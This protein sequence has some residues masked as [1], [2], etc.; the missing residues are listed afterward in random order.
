MKMVVRKG[1]VHGR[2]QVLH[3]KEIEYILAAKMRCKVLYIGITNP[4]HAYTRET[5]NDIERSKKINN[6]M[7]YLERYEMIESALTQFGVPRDE[8]KIIPF[9]IN[10]PDILLGYSPEDARYFM[11]IHDS[12][13]EE[14]CEILRDLGLDVEVLWRRP[15]SEK[16]ITGAEVRR[17][18]GFYKQWD[19][20][21]PRSVYDY[22]RENKIDERIIKNLTEIL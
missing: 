19:H 12:W 10:R 14:K 1:V 13:G 7:T 16:G 15:L 11:T 21:V 2:F 22:V 17:K 4:D 8:F 3:L 18:I 20:L 6:P 5:I 9:P